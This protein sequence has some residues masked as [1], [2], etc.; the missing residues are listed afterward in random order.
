VNHAESNDLQ[1]Q[2]AL[3]AAAEAIREADTIIDAVKD[4]MGVAATFK[5]YDQQE[6]RVATISKFLDMAM[7]EINDGDV[8]AEGLLIVAARAM[9][10]LCAELVKNQEAAD[11]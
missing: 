7:R 4:V 6:R 2:L 1:V 3:I 8:P 10:L 9:D 5:K 11:A